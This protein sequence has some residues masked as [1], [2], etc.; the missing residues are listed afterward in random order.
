MISLEADLEDLGVALERDLKMLSEP[1]DGFFLVLVDR[2]KSGHP[3]L[4][5][6]IGKDKPALDQGDLSFLIALYSSPVPLGLSA[7]E[8]AT[9]GE[10]A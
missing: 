1:L 3:L 7:M 10:E 4:L 5:E 8:N 2:L 6:R 9:T